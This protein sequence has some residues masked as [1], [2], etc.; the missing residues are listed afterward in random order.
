[1]QLGPALLLVL[2]GAGLEG[3]A[4]PGDEGLGDLDGRVALRHHDR[5]HGVD[6]DA[7]V[8]GLN[9]EVVQRVGHA[10]ANL[11]RHTQGGGCTTDAGPARSTEASAGQRW[12]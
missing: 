6:A 5:S 12:G 8:G 10:G 11:R 7:H 4:V 2:F 1:M 9:E 3:A